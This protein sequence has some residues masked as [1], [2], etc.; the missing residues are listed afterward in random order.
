MLFRLTKIFATT[1]VV[2]LA[3]MALA[4]CGG[5]EPQDVSFDFAVVDRALTANDTTFV[6]TQGDTVT[7]NLSADEDAEFHVH[8]YELIQEVAAGE[9]ATITFEANATGRF[10]VEMHVSGA[11]DT[12]DADDNDL[13]GEVQTPAEATAAYIAMDDAEETDDHDHEADEHEHEGEGVDIA[14]GAIEIRPR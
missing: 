2:A 8:G 6:A 7:L 14:L 11:A 4:A 12:H 3:A 13:D 10:S 5:S 9:S 1:T